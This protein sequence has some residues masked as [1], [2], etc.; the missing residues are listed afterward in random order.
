[1]ICD[2]SIWYSCMNVCRIEEISMGRFFKNEVY[3]IGFTYHQ[4]H[5]STYVGNWAI[6]SPAKV[7]QLKCPLVGPVN[8]EVGVINSKRILNGFWGIPA[9]G[10]GGVGWGGGM[11]SSMKSQGAFTSTPMGVFVDFPETDSEECSRH[12]MERWLVY[13]LS[14][15]HL[16]EVSMMLHYNT[17]LPRQSFATSAKILE[18]LSY[19]YHHWQWHLE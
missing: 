18:V 11:G 15:C 19:F 14:A 17:H 7:P 16:W 13:R 2:I 6:P 8:S 9:E 4:L 5:S 10:G 3:R 12:G 1:M